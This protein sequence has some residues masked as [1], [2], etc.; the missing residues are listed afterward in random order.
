[1]LMQRVFRW[2]CLALTVSGLAGCGDDRDGSPPAGTS[3]RYYPVIGCESIDPAPCDVNATACQEKLLNLAACMR[4]SEPG[5]LPPI[6]HMTVNE[7]AA[8]LREE[9][10][11]TKPSPDVPH[12]A[13]TLTLLGLAEAG[14][15]DTDATVMLLSQSVAAFYRDDS[16]DVVLIDRPDA[17]PIDS[18]ATLLHELVHAL[19]DRESD[20]TAYKLAHF[21]ADSDAFLAA[22]SV[23]E[24]EARFHEDVFAL[25]LL[26]LDPRTIDLTTLFE[27]VAAQD[28]PAFL[29]EP[30]PILVAPLVFPYDWGAR[31][32]HLRWTDHQSILDL[33]A[34]PPKTTHTIMSSVTRVVDDTFEP[35]DIEAPSPPDA[36]GLVAEDDL[37][38]FATFLML[39]KLTDTDTA[40]NFGLA[41][42][43]D[44]LSVYAGSEAAGDPSATAFAW[45]CDF[46]SE[47]HASG[48]AKLIQQGLT[49]ID[50]RVSGTRLTVAASD[51]GSN[52]D[53][54]FAASSP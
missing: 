5:E 44:H 21:D 22:D 53:W 12:V 52:I 26:G 32:V 10:A 9:V 16:D 14:A 6:T 29:A 2:G 47:A 23:V 45:S 25:S 15:L 4:G 50:V 3:K 8:S 49:D 1:M 39:Q 27:N 31:Y 37:G 35:K 7:Y 28:E 24:G 11:Q 51:D 19:Q 54:A 18:N 17:D 43:G 38:A 40:R 36:W 34:A 33:L 30:S 41:W 42:R 13:A 20:I 46:D 48:A